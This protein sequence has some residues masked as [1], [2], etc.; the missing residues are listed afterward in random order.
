[1]HQGCLL[2]GSRV[3]KPPS[4]QARILLELHLSHPGIVRMKELARSYVWWPRIDQDIEKTVRDCNCCQL[5]Q[6]QPS[7]AP[8]HPWEWPARTWQRVHIDFAGPFLGSIS[9]LLVDA[10]SKWP[11]VVPMQSTT[12]TKT[13]ECLRTIVVRQGLPEQLLSD[14]G[15]QFVSEQ[16]QDFLQGNGIQHIQSTPTIRQPTALLNGSSTPSSTP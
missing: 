1:M 6:K 7:S 9:L 13:V 8:L 4:L 12:A 16:F 5:Q 15:P 10:R 3:A 11:E 14:N 2:W